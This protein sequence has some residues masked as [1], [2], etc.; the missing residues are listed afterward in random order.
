MNSQIKVHFTYLAVLFLFHWR[1]KPKK[2]QHTLSLVEFLNKFSALKSFKWRVQLFKSFSHVKL[3]S[4]AL[5]FSYSLENDRFIKTSSFVPHN[6]SI[7]YLCLFWYNQPLSKVHR[8]Q[9]NE[10]NSELKA[11]PV[12]LTVTW[13]FSWV[14]SYL[15]L[16]HPSFTDIHQK[17]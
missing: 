8:W 14:S 11:N 16:Y 3:F 5:F 15:E 10:G 6:R 9:S 1:Q 17:C 12:N 7:S 4:L 13:F 2:W